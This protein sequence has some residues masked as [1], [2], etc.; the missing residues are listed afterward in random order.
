[1]RRAHRDLFLSVA[2]V[3]RDDLD[4]PG[5]ELRT[6]LGQLVGVEI[7]LER[8]R[9]ELAF[10]D[11]PAL[12]GFVEEGAG[13]CFND[14]RQLSSLLLVKVLCVPGEPLSERPP[15]TR[16]SRSFNASESRDIPLMAPVRGRPP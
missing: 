16:R 3:D 9:F 11:Q 4:V 10:R 12:L 6:Q 13:R 1:V 7:V 2:R 8:E 14:V 15:A 5:A